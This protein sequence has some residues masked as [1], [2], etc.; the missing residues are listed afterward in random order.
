MIEGPGH[1]PM[2]KIRENMDKQ[3]TVCHEAPFYTLGPLVTDIAPG[4]DHI[5]SAIGAAMI[6]WFG[7]AMLCYVTPKEHL[8]C[9]TARTSRTASSPTRS[10]RTPRT[11]PRGT[12]ARPRATMRFRGRALPSAGRISSTCRSIPDTAR[13]FHDETLPAASGQRRPFLLHVRPAVLFHA[14]H[15]GLRALPVF[16]P[17]GTVRTRKS[18]GVTAAGGVP[19]V[20][21][22]SFEPATAP[23]IFPTAS[24]QPPSVTCASPG[25]PVTVTLARQ[26]LVNAAEVKHEI[27]VDEDI[28]V[29]VAEETKLNARGCIVDEV[30]ARL[31]GEVGVVLNPSHRRDPAAIGKGVPGNTV[32]R[33]RAGR[34]EILIALAGGPNRSSAAMVPV[35][36]KVAQ[37]RLGGVQSIEGKNPP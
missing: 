2:H 11:W 27:A 16:K 10:R 33:Q 30:V 35:G 25:S 36:P 24:R 8:G 6:G 15:P 34:E 1:V 37:G 14:H 19:L 18:S 29:V 22:H 4:Y 20:G 13:Q 5:T 28:E 9:P 31:I 17:S 26:L 12:R 3:L 32:G 21:E 23:W 7:T